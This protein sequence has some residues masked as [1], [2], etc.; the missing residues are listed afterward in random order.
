MKIKNSVV[1]GSWS[2]R[3]DKEVTGHKPRFFV[4]RNRF[5]T[6]SFIYPSL[7]IT[8]AHLPCFDMSLSL[9]LCPAAALAP[10][11]LMLWRPIFKSG[12]HFLTMSAKFLRI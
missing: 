3:G 1:S 5:F 2:T 10:P 12:K 8:K 6:E 4:I 9:M 7:A 11:D